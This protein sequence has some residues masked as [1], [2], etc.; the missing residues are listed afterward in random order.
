MYIELGLQLTKGIARKAK[1]VDHAT[2]ESVEVAI[3][4]R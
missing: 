4:T 3:L 2:Q 1:T